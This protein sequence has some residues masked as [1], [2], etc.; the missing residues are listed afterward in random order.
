R[1]E[2]SRVD[3]RLIVDFPSVEVEKDRSLLVQCAADA[4]AV[5]PHLKRRVNVAIQERIAGV[6]YVVAG[7]E[8]ALAVPGIRARLGQNFNAPVPQLVVFGENGFW[9]MRI[10]RIADF[11]GM[12]PP[13]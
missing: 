4:S 3:Y 2:R 5:M 8:I 1:I 6:E 11:G 13:V 10:S 9:L 12:R 7:L